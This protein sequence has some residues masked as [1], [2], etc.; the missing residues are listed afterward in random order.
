MSASFFLAV[1][2]LS[3]SAAAAER[4]VARLGADTQGGYG[5]LGSLAVTE[6]G[7]FAGFDTG[8]STFLVLDT[9]TWSPK[10]APV[11][12]GHTGAAVW[13]DTDGT[14]RFY[15]GCPDGTIK[16]L[17]VEADG[18]VLVQTTAWSTG[19]D[20]VV[21]VETDGAYVYAVH[22]ADSVWS[23]TALSV[24]DGSVDTGWPVQIAA[25]SV[26]D[27]MLGGGLLIVLDGGSLIS[28][29][30]LITKVPSTTQ[31]D[32]S[33]PRWV[34]GFVYNDSAL[35]M[36]DSGG[37][38]GFVNIAN[39][40]YQNIT[41]PGDVT[42][43]VTAV[44]L[45]ADQGRFYASTADDLYIYSFDGGYATDQQ[46][47][48][49][50]AGGVQEFGALSAATDWLLGINGDGEVLVVS[51]APW[52]MVGAVNPVSA[53]EGESVTLAFTS[54]RAG[55]WELR[56]GGTMAQDGALLESGS[57]AAG[58]SVTVPLTVTDAYAE[59]EN[60]LWVFVEGAD[61]LVGHDAGVLDVDNPPG[62]VD[63]T[64]TAGEQSVSV[65]FDRLTDE[66]IAE[67]KFYLTT[68]P[69]TAGEWP[70]GGPAYFGPDRLAAAGVDVTPAVPGEG[71]RI[72]R[73]FYPLTNGVT[74][75][76]AV[77][78]VD[79]AGTEG[80]MSEVRA[81]TPT[82][83]VGAAQ[84]AGEDG[85]FCGAPVAASAALACAGLGLAAARRR[86]A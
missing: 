77:R 15:T 62:G 74:Y 16:E 45:S 32:V 50:L 12:A 6:D 55:G 78:A 57:V 35:F 5:S 30:D 83:T 61:G 44:G 72:T 54:D 84:L 58:E 7:A 39:T 23:V 37:T 17:R 4:L 64:A 66:D 48:I 65:Q 3:S 79:D 56:R 2:Q 63:M 46:Q 11:C 36:A 52:V 40:L 26:Q 85:G 9:G 8:G 86:R 13:T 28:K 51:G 1:F 20:P 81:V 73:T 22:G 14:H 47:I 71:D 34:E 49:P 10:S 18:D 82:P 75:Y 43:E 19:A 59:G 80:P 53:V 67:Y 70:S 29:V 68:E 69:F 76:V 21:A 33:Y 42:E 60:R 31:G 27:T 24:A 38:F 41:Y 25:T